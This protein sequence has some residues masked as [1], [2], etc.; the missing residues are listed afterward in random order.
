MSGDS[1]G[2]RISPLGSVRGFPDFKADRDK[3]N[4]YLTYWRDGIYGYQEQ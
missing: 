2:W 4:V 1:M 3:A